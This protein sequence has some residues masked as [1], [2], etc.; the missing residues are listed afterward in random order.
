MKRVNDVW[1][2]RAR[3]LIVGCSVCLLAQRAEAEFAATVDQGPNDPITR[4]ARLTVTGLRAEYLES[5][6]G[7]DTRTPRLSWQIRTSTRGMMQSAYQI[8]VAPSGRAL[9]SA[10]ELLWDSGKVTLGESIFRPY[11][12]P[13]LESAHRYFWQVRIWD[14]HGSVSDWSAPAFWEMGLLSATD[15][16]AQ[17]IEP[18]VSEASSQPNPAPLLRKTFQLQRGVRR[19]RAYITSHG[20]YEMYINGHRVGDQLFAPGWTSYHKRLQYQTYDITALLTQGANAIGVVLGD[21]WYRGR[22]GLGDENTFV[23]HYYGRRLAAL[24]QLEV[25]Y[26]DGEK[27]TIVTDTSWK[28]S[29]GPILMSEIYAGETYDARLEKPG[30]TTAEYAD[31]DWA[32]VRPISAPKDILVGLVSPPVRRIEELKPVRVFITPAGDTVADMGQNMVGWVR[33]AVQGPA[34]TTVTLRHAEVLDA[35]GN[36]YTANLGT[37][38]AQIRYTLKGQGLE[39]FEPH[40]TFQGFRFVAVSGYPGAVTADRLTGI[41]IHSDLKRT[42]DFTSSSELVNQLYHNILWSQKGNFLDVPTDCPQR[43]ERMGW[44]GDAQVFSA[45]AAL[46]MDVAGFLAK[47]LADLAADQSSS[48]RVPWI[49]PDLNIPLHLPNGTTPP[50]GGAAGWGDA[51]TVIPWNLYQAYGDERILAQQYDSMMR[52]VQFEQTRAGDDYVWEGDFQFGDWLDFF[53]PTPKSADFLSSTPTALVATAYFA[54]SVD[55]L[56]R[57]AA[58]LGR[59]ED[60]ARYA[61]LLEHIKAAFSARFVSPIGV[62]GQG[63]QS[64]YVLAL[65]FDLLPQSLRGLAVARLAQD[66]RTRGHLT[67]GFLGTPHLLNVLS[68]Y[69]YLN[70]AYRLL[71]RQ[72]FPSWLYPVEHGATTIWERWDGIKPDGS[73]PQVSSFNHYAYGSVGEW[74]Y[75]AMAGIRIDPDVPGY[76]HVLIEPQPGGGLTSVKASHVTLYGTVTSSWRAD[77]GTFHLTVLIPPNATATVR[78]PSARWSGVLEGGKPVGVSRGITG[79]QQVGS[80]MIV[81]VGSGQYEFSYPMADSQT[82]DDPR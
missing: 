69:G 3:M 68:R 4:N 52:W 58:V 56:E 18:S 1:Q 42:G 47:W 21:G 10:G 5:P 79:L 63:T 59:Q 40:F 54:H 81:E 75:G 34:G 8:R 60:A 24:V 37:A 73:L 11:G 6:I 45:T 15:W 66:V 38:A 80:A 20:L 7:I 12:G 31:S 16:K 55:I 64:A 49:V 51:A 22:L 50:P 30:W 14:E 53:G 39:V 62:V 13:A 57:T 41:V 32:G 67:T 46:N 65:D 44:T 19:A 2:T 70:E 29:T 26:E 71:E 74:M 33:L 48:G 28:A 72:E 43:D 78:L 77:A 27:E 61:Q 82:S 9:Q 25:T 17:W 36:F 35:K 23:D 76:R